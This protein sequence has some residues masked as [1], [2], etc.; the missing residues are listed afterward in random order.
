MSVLCDVSIGKILFDLVCLEKSEGVTVEELTKQINP[1]SLDLTIGVKYRRAAKCFD[2]VTY[3]FRHEKEA[4][5]YAGEKY[6]KKCCAKSGYILLQPGDAVLACTREYIR[7]PQNLSGQIFTK[8]T[9]GRM[10]I[11]HMMAGFVDPGFQGRLT[12]ELVNEGPHCVK[13]PV[14][15]RTVQMI[16]SKLDKKAAAYSGRYFGAEEVETAKSGVR[17]QGSGISDQ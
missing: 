10:F 6:W 14:G 12:L 8:S 17:I 16:L 5:V 3:G 2:A 15:A 11:N 1:A 7:M 13:I 9:L 4:E